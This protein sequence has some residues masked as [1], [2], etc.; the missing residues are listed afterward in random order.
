MKVDYLS[1][2]GFRLSDYGKYSTIVLFLPPA[3]HCRSAEPPLGASA[4]APGAERSLPRPPRRASRPLRRPRGRAL[5]GSF[6]ATRLPGA[7]AASETFPGAEAGAR[8]R[9][10]RTGRP[11]RAR[12]RHQVLPGAPQ[13]LSLF[14]HLFYG[15]WLPLLPPLRPRSPRPRRGGRR[16]E[17]G[18]PLRRVLP[19]SATGRAGAAGGRRGEARAGRERMRRGSL[20][21]F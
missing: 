21:G 19:G 8:V 1:E 2:F 13:P 6:P 20:W 10:G 9:G 5:R 16:G 11:G 12:G 3:P 18:A 14:F 4:G 17:P 7:A 15:S